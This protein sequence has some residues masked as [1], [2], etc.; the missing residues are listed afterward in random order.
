MLPIPFEVAGPAAVVAV[1]AVAA[2]LGV[3]AF[4]AI[5][6]VTHPDPVRRADAQRVLRELMRMLDH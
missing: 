6:A 3:V 5:F 2:Y 1:A 4:V